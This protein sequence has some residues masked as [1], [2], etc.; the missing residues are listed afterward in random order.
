[1]CSHFHVD[2]GPPEQLRGLTNRIT[3]EVHQRQ[4]GTIFRRELLERPF[5]DFSRVAVSA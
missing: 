3:V 5:Q 4:D 2:Q 1:M